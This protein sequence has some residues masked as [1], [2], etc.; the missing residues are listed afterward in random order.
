MEMHLSLTQLARM[1]GYANVSKGHRR[2]DMFERTGHAIPIL[3]A[4]LTAAL[5]ID[6][7]TRNRLEY[8]DYKDWLGTPAN[9]PTPYLLEVDPGLHRRARGG[10]DRRGDGAVRRRLCEEMRHGGVPRPRQEDTGEVRSGRVATGTSS[11]H[12]RRRTRGKST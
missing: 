4:K 1:V 7:R 3:F 6:E 5:G 9:P 10:E 2:I 11:R 12:Y 8:Q